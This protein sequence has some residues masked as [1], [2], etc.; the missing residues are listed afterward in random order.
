MYSIHYGLGFSID[1]F[2]P[3]YIPLY[4]FIYLLCMFTFRLVLCQTHIMIRMILQNY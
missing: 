3:V 1:I 4:V 2:E